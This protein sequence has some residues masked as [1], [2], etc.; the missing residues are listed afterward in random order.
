MKRLIRADM[1]KEDM[2]KTITDNNPAYNEGATW[3]RT[4]DDIADVQE[5]WTDEDFGMYPDFTKEMAEKALKEGKVKVYSSKPFELGS[6]VTPSKMYAESYSGNGK[7]Y[8]K[9]MNLKDIAWIDEG[10]GQIVKL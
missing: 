3:I 7:I 5:L 8:S 6:F 4:E 9:E 10:E 2:V 1:S